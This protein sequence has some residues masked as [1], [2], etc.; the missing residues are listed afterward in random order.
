VAE[1]GATDDEIVEAG[2][3]LSF[4]EFLEVHTRFIFGSLSS[5]HFFLLVESLLFWF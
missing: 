3:E 2:Q 1:E 4:N 5:L